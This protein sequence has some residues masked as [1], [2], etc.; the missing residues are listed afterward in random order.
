MEFDH[1]PKLPL[2]TDNDIIYHKTK[3][4]I[5]EIK[6]FKFRFLI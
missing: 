2:I 5:T 4:S 3:E 1:L 6:L